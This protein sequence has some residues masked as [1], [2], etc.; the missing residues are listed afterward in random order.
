MRTVYLDDEAEGD[1]TISLKKQTFREED[2]PPMALDTMQ[3]NA[4]LM[5][6]VAKA[7]GF[8]AKKITTRAKLSCT[9]GVSMYGAAAES[10]RE[11]GIEDAIPYMGDRSEEMVR[12]ANTAAD[13]AKLYA[14]IIPPLL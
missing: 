5:E 4:A 1:K 7:T 9:E 3:K 8:S 6:R 13:I 10:L 11:A 14:Y 2:L 12:S